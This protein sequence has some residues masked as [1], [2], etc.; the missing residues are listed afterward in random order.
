MPFVEWISE[1]SVGIEEID[2]ENQRLIGLLN[3]LHDAVE[4]GVGHE[5]PGHLLDGLPRYMSYHFAHEEELFLQT[6]YPAYEEHCQLHKRLT[7]MVWEVYEESQTGD[8]AVTPDQVLDFL[9]DWLCEH[10][11]E[12]D[13]AFGVYVSSN[14][15]AL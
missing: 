12:A 6:S 11:M 3:E 13:R 15:I 2:N 9:R 8:A 5:V 10:I 4:E 14:R 7:A 1:F